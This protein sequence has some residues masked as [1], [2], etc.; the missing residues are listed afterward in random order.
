MDSSRRLAPGAH[1]IPEGADGLL[2]TTPAEEVARV[3]LPEGDRD[4]LLEVLTGQL[5]VAD[6]LAGAEDPDLLSDVFEGCADEGITGPPPAATTGGTVTVV[7]D[8]PV[9][10]VLAPLL[11]SAGFTVTADG[12]VLVSCAGW[13]PD[14]AWQRLDTDRAGRPWH[15]C[16]I[17]GT[18][19]VLGPFSVPGTPTYL[20]ARTRRLAASAWP[21]ELETLWRHLDAATDLP[22]VPW[23]DPGVLAVAAGLITADLVAHRAGRRPPGADR[24]V[25]IDPAGL[26]WSA[27]PVLPLPTGIMRMAA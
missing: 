14:A 1:A 18:R 13:L 8:N 22:P 23:P 7:G 11:E 9:T 15:R 19:L 5:A 27:H 26:T 20:D 6:A 17:E 21:D 25:V 2:L 4:L 16:H 24:Q 3:Q 12:E 10:A